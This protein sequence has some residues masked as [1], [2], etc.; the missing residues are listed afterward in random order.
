MG[1]KRQRTTPVSDSE[2][3]EQGTSRDDDDTNGEYRF[4][5]NDD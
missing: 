3:P 2:V 5:D 1:A 4:E